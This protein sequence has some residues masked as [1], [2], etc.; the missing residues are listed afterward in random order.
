MPGTIIDSMVVTL[1]LDPRDFQKGEQAAEASLKQLQT[2]AGSSSVAVQKSTGDASMSF[3]NLGGSIG[4]V[5]ETLVGFGKKFLGVLAVVAGGKA[6]IDTFTSSIQRMAETGRD[7]NIIGMSTQQLS[8]WQNA[9][10]GVGGDPATI[11]GTLRSSAMA[12]EGARDFGQASGFTN[13][14]QS[15]GI[16]ASNPDGTSRDL[17]DIY[18]DLSNKFHG[19]NPQ[20]AVYWANLAGLDP[21]TTN[22]LLSQGGAA[23]KATVTQNA[24]VT[25][26]EAFDA[27]GL[28]QQWSVLAADQQKV[29]NTLSDVAEPAIAK[30]TRHFIDMINKVNGSDPTLNTAAGKATDFIENA[31]KDVDGWFS[32][33]G[34]NAAQQKANLQQGMAYFQSQ[35]WTKDQAAGIMANFYGESHLDPNAVSPDG[36]A[37][38]LGQWRG[39]RWKRLVAEY[40]PNPTAAQQFAFTQQELM[41]TESAAAA[42]LKASPS[43]F[44]AGVAFDTGFERNGGGWF[45]Q[46]VRGANAQTIADQFSS[47]SL[48]ALKAHHAMVASSKA[49]T[50]I[51]VAAP[52]VTVNAKN[53][54][55]AAVAKQ[56]GRQLSAAIQAG[57]GATGLA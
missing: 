40:G 16:Q 45:S 20:Q 54:D 8:G 15:L 35:G 51:T 43:S 46:N 25:P 2:T 19:M 53:A 22:L 55:A 57:L 3:A 49:G 37:H 27:Q 48:A 23:L 41:T 34:V 26:G 9:I 17:T 56:T 21:D 42:K 47:T 11:T 13:V 14:L 6:L 1:G 5:G 32:H 10:K 29:A 30:I 39:D 7:A 31:G 18:G 24:S 36:G 50:T 44:S 28:Q 33:K 12:L 4:G 38:G 52:V